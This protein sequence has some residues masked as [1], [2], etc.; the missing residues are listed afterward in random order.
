[1]IN[2]S[3]TGNEAEDGGGMFNVSSSPALINVS[4]SGN[5]A[6]MGVGGMKNQYSSPQIRNSIIWGNVGGTLSSIENSVLSATPTISYSIVEDSNEDDA[7][8]SSL[9]ADHGH[10]GDRNPL[11][12]DP[13]DPSDPGWAPTSG[14]DYRLQSGSPAKDTGQDSLYPNNADA[15]VFSGF[16]LSDTAKPAINT[17]LD[18][19][20]A[21]NNRRNGAIDR[22]AYEVQ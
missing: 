15:S 4:I 18:L 12:M 22:G 11:F 1:L 9:G 20:L 21:G 14:G 2:V 10:N 16:T 17:A 5:K 19:D 7:L 3:I 6:N 13:I 8:D